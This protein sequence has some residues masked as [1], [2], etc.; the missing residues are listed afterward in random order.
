MRGRMNAIRVA[1]GL[2]CSGYM[3]LI[4]LHRNRVSQTRS[5]LTNAWPPWR[6]KKP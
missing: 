3:T 2:Q 5:W 1:W 6:A 4:G